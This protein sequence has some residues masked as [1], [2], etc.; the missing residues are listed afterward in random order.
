MKI[1][2]NNKEKGE[3]EYSTLLKSKGELEERVSKDDENKKKI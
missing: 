1:L 2:E 3:M